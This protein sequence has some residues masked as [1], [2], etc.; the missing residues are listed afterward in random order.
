MSTHVNLPKPPRTSEHISESHKLVRERS[1]PN[2][3]S[4]QDI[5]SHLKS[6]RSTG[7]LIIDIGQGGVGTIRFKE[8]HK[9]RFEDE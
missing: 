7:Q 5:L 4:I 1:F 8:E 3:Q 9:V 2:S 6:T